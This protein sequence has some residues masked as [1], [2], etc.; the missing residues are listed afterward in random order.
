MLDIWYVE[1]LPYKSNVKLAI[2]TQSRKILSIATTQ[3]YT[4]TVVR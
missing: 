1:G 2:L 3:C 4:Q